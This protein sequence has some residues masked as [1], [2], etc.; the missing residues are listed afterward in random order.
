MDKLV[1]RGGRALEGSVRVAGSKNAV[2]PVLAA[3]LLTDEPLVVPNAPRVRDVGTML[4]VLRDLGSEVEQRTDGSV[5]VRSAAGPQRRG[6]LGE[7]APHAGLGGGARAAPGAQRSGRRE[8][9]RGLRDRRAP[10]RPAPQGACEALGAR[11]EVRPRGHRGR[12]PRP[13]GC[14]ARSST[15]AAPSGPT[16]LGTINVMMAAVLARGRTVIHGRGLRA[17]GG[18]RRGLPALDG[19]GDPRAWARRASRSRASSA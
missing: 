8:P 6:Q 15:W 17:R 1:I 16:V 13:A 7:R 5:Y 11:I 18:R 3:S 12:G 19:R 2:L 14:A 4:D 10:D 9:A